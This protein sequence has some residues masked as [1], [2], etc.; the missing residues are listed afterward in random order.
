MIRF[1]FLHHVGWRGCVVTA[2]A[3]ALL[4]TGSVHA[5]PIPQAVP[6]LDATTFGEMATQSLTAESPGIGEDLQQLKNRRFS[7]LKSKIEELSELLEKPARSGPKP[8][9]AGTEQKNI[10]SQKT[11]NGNGLPA[12]P[13]REMTDSARDKTSDHPTQGKPTLQKPTLLPDLSVSPIPRQMSDE[14]RQTGIFIVPDEGMSSGTISDQMPMEQQVLA[15]PIDRF[16][17]ANSLFGA[18]DAE[19]CLNVLK[20][21]NLQQ[22]SREDQLWVTYMQACCHRRAGRTDE[23]RLHYRRV[24]AAPEADWMKD[25]SKWWLDNLDAKK[26]VRDDVQTL[27]GTLKAWEGELDRLGQK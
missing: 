18:G 19:A 4:A 1:P 25:V 16:S 3:G 26:T 23:A 11:P 6:L 7:E 8:A 14:Q 9:P 12:D 2:V 27:S 10:P 22:L 20:Q 24:A 5:D 13:L 15:G 21:T 17:L